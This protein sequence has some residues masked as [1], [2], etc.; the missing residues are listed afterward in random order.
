[1][2]LKNSFAFTETID[3]IATGVAGKTMFH[4]GPLSPDYWLE[5]LKK[6]VSVTV[7]RKEVHSTPTL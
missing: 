2:V 4:V 5:D 7:A 3:T 6:P 1:M